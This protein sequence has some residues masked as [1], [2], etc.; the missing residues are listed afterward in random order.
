M[1]R[2]QGCEFWTVLV[3]IDH[4]NVWNGCGVIT[5]SSIK[6]LF[7]INTFQVCFRKLNV[8]W[9]ETRNFKLKPTHDHLS[10]SWSLGS[11]FKNRIRQGK[12]TDFIP[13]ISLNYISGF[14][15]ENTTGTNGRKLWIKMPAKD[16][17]EIIQQKHIT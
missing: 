17:S 5:S 12:I 11:C 9:N 15:L 2:A 13:E 1:I 7:L 14:T 6:K 16:K 3:W 4:L 10:S 8:I